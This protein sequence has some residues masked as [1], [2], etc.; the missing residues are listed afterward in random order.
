MDSNTTINY[1]AQQEYQEAL[2]DVTIVFLRAMVTFMMY[3]SFEDGAILALEELGE[4]GISK[5]RTLTA[6]NAIY[7]TPPFITFDQAVD[8]ID[9][10]YLNIIT[11]E[12]ARNELRQY[13]IFEL[14]C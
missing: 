9:E 10:F 5:M 13:F 14:D 12:E 8:L 11:R 4:T 3:N 2:K 7:T 6:I 1:E